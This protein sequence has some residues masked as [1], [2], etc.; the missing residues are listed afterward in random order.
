MLSLLYDSPAICCRLQKYNCTL[1][2]VLSSTAQKWLIFFKQSIS[3]LYS[4]NCNLP[5]RMSLCGAAYRL[6][7]LSSFWDMDCTF[8]VCSLHWWLGGAALL[9][10][11]WNCLLLYHLFLNPKSTLWHFRPEDRCQVFGSVFCI[12]K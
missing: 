5:C 12:F 3:A 8:C 1:N 7:E 6:V 11:L 10:Q 2:H 4:C 9:V